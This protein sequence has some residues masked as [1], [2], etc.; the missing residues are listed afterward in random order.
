[1]FTVSSINAFIGQAR[2]CLKRMKKREEMIYTR[3]HPQL[4]FYKNLKKNNLK[5]NKPK[6]FN[7]GK[8]LLILSKNR[9][10]EV[11]QK[12]HCQ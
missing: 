12:I 7:D 10:N 11:I 5:L 8:A 3:R 9:L 6:Q 2:E 1:M 4:T